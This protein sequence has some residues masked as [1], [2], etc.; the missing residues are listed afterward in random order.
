MCLLFAPFQLDIGIGRRLLSYLLIWVLL[1]L[2][3]NE[4]G[5]Q[6]SKIVLVT[7]LKR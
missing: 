2:L 6:K 1:L 3:L 4:L 5:R 7:F